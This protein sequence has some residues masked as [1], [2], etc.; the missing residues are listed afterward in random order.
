M[1]H[2]MTVRGAI[3][4]SELV[5]TLS[6]EHI[7]FGVS[8]TVVTKLLVD[9]SRRLLSIDARSNVTPLTPRIAPRA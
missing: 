7:S 6:G 1:T 4:P 8:N 5:P 2:V 9:N 3:A